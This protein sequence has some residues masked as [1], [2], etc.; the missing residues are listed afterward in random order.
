M[1]LIPVHPGT[2]ARV[3]EADLSLVSGYNWRLLKTPRS[4]YAQAS[5]EGK[6]IL[7]HRVILGAEPGQLVDHE[8]HDGLD[9]RRANIRACTPQQNCFNQ[10]GRSSSGFKCVSYEPGKRNKASPWRVRPEING[11]RHN[12]GRYRT[13]QEAHAAYKVFIAQHHGEFA[14]ADS[15]P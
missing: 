11:K 7:M 12:L 15:L 6:T 13:P 5:H 2:F 8:N 14:C 1:A 3:D 10:R 9:N 4:I